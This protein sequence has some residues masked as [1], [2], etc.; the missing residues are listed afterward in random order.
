[1]SIEIVALIVLILLMLGTIVR[2]ALG[3]TTWDRLIGIGLISSMITIAAIVMALHFDESYILDVA[4]SLAIIGFLAKVLI[5]R[6]IE[7]SGNV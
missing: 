3:P 2:I 6:Y 5:A 1:M 4:L 7:R